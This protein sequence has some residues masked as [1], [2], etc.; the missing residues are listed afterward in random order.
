MDRQWQGI[1]YVNDWQSSFD[2]YN[3]IPLDFKKNIKVKKYA[4]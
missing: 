4:F 1:T 3:K 2:I